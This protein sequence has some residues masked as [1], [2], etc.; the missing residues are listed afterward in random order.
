M[1]EIINSVT[2]FSILFWASIDKVV[3]E[4]RAFLTVVANIV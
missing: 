4:G 1:K 2:L 3:E